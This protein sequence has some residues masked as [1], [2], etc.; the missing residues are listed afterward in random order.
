MSQRRIL[1]VS[2]HY[3]P[4]TK[5]GGPPV[6]IFGLAKAL[7]SRGY[8][9]HAVTFF[10]EDSRRT[11][12]VS[13]EGV[14]V[15]YLPWLGW[16]TR[17]FATRT[18]G[19]HEA[20]RES[21]IVH[22]FGLYNF[23]TP[24]AARI[25]REQG[26]PL[27]VE[28]L[29]NFRPQA[30]N[31]LVKRCYHR[32]FTGRMF[33]DAAAVIATS[34]A[35][36]AELAQAVNAA[37]LKVRGNGI[38][39]LPLQSQADRKAARKLM[40]LSDEMLVI[41]FV[42]RI[43]PIKNLEMLVE[44]FRDAALPNARLFLVGP[45]TEPDY[46]R[47]LQDLIRA[48]SLEKRIVLPGALYGK[49]KLAAYAASDFFV[50]PSISESYGNAA[51]EAVSAGLPVLLTDTCGIAPVVAGPAGIAVACTRSGLMEGLR[52]TASSE[53]RRALRAAA[54]ELLPRL[55]WDE[56]VQRQIEI[57]HAVSGNESRRE[58]V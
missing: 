52:L 2:P 12:R 17:Q 13:M 51:A 5:F 42:G 23:L 8:R 40:G 33:R 57:Y 1:Q 53:R 32:L 24:L 44:S 3:Y 38:E 26:K 34:E 28:P 31:L 37:R 14:E 9:V 50:L 21:D 36:K 16:G 25:A 20:V 58:R 7:Q 6:K 48:N 19:L 15:Q 55:A 29:G 54:E 43:S 49:E 22:V 41:L 56:P 46:L 30:R 11:S 18:A 47:R 27:V 10:S 35:E 45:Q 39:L 4:E